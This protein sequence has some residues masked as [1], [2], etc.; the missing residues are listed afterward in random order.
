M[1]SLQIRRIYLQNIY[2]EKT[3][4]VFELYKEMPWLNYKTTIQPTV[5]KISEWTLH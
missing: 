5:G 3:F 1:C 4:S 2:L